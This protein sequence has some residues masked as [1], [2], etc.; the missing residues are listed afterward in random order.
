MTGGDRISGAGEI[1]ICALSSG[2][3]WRSSRGGRG[4]PGFRA[5]AS[6]ASCHERR[7]RGI[8][9]TYRIHAG[10]TDHFVPSHLRTFAP[11]HC[12]LQKGQ[13]PARSLSSTLGTGAGPR[14]QPAEPSPAPAFSRFGVDPD[15][16]RGSRKLGWSCAGQHVQSVLLYGG[17]RSTNPTS[18]PW[19]GNNCLSVL[20]FVRHPRPPGLAFLLI[21]RPARVMLVRTQSTVTS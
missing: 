21:S 10:R 12:I 15:A 11:S 3:A 14:P 16:S 20:R 7:R 1:S 9:S 5:D 18:R 17:T 2:L 6:T 13:D 8:R 4:A 19:P